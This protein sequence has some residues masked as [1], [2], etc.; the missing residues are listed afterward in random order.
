MEK[1]KAYDKRIRL[2][3]ILYPKGKMS[4]SEW[5]KIVQMY[6]PTLRKV[7]RESE[8]GRIMSK[9][10]RLTR[11]HKPYIMFQCE[12]GR[13]NACEATPILVGEMRACMSCYVK[14]Y[15][16]ISLMK[17]KKIMKK[18]C[19]QC[20]SNKNKHLDHIIPKSNGGPNILT[21]Y[22]VLCFDCH[23]AKHPWL[24]PMVKDRRIPC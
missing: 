6:Q 2:A 21:N 8:Y 4:K 17:Y 23:K 20:G 1:I 5:I 15:F 3:Y 9:F 14:D 24:T 16:N 22:Q 7:L 10:K 12:L 13:H 19:I 11:Y 18:P